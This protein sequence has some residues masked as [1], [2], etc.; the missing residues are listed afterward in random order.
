[1]YEDG[2]TD[3]DALWDDLISITEDFETV[4]DGIL[5]NLIQLH[6]DWTQELNENLSPEFLGYADGKGNE[7]D[8]YNHL[9]NAID[10][11]SGREG[12]TEPLTELNIVYEEDPEEE[13]GQIFTINNDYDDIVIP[14]NKASTSEAE[15]FENPDDYEEWDSWKSL[16]YHDPALKNEE[17][18][19]TPNDHQM[20]NGLRSMFNRNHDDWTN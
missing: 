17:I 18:L 20:V 16:Y 5:K 10:E 2:T 8:K 9:E 13:E 7:F 19:M 3:E 11:L 4:Y 14:E 1:M 6:N 15:E 12:I